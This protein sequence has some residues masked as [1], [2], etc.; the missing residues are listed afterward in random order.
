[1][2]VRNTLTGE[3]GFVRVYTWWQ[4]YD[5]PVFRNGEIV[6]WKQE[7]VEILHDRPVVRTVRKTKKEYY[8]PFAGYT[9]NELEEMYWE[10]TGETGIKRI[11]AVLTEWYQ[12]ICSKLWT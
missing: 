4:G 12:T 7:H 11:V 2:R 3:E 9:E 5:F 1:M 6:V 10:L 8:D